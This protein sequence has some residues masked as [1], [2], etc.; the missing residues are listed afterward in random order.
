LREVDRGHIEIRI[1]VR[2]PTVH[3]REFFAFHRSNRPLVSVPAR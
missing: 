1:L 2:S 3:G